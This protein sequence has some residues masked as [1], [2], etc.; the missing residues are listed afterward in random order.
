MKPRID[1][2]SG[3]VR[4]LLAEDDVRLAALLEQSLR[5]AGWQVEVVHD[6]RSADG[7]ALPDG[8]P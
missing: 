5:E 1:Q 4:V 8:L 6:G 3:G 7:L 2:A